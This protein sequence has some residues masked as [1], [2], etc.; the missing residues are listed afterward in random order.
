MTCSIAW[1][2]DS[3]KKNQSVSLAVYHHIKVFERAA[4]ASFATTQQRLSIWMSNADRTQLSV[5]RWKVEAS[6]NLFMLLYVWT[7]SQLSYRGKTIKTF[8]NQR[9]KINANLINYHLAIEYQSAPKMESLKN[10]LSFADR[11]RSRAAGSRSSAVRSVCN[12]PQAPQHS[13]KRHFPLKQ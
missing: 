3:E 6:D 8:Y 7:R 12:D 11:S 4:D 5:Q 9:A 1:R 10:A 2:D 13:L